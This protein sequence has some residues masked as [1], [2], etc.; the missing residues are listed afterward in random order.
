[1][2]VLDVGAYFGFFTLHFARLTQAQG[3]VYA[4]EIDP[5]ILPLLYENIATNGAFNAEVVEVG[6]LD[7]SE[8]LF[9]AGQGQLRS[10]GDQST[11]PGVA[12]VAFDDWRIGRDIP[13]VDLVKMD[14]EGAELNALLGMQQLLC[15]DGPLLL[16][17]VHPQFIENFDHRVG[18]LYDFLRSLGYEIFDVNGTR[19]DGVSDV[20][21]ILCRRKTD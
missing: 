14:I 6:L 17:E 16:I 4:F 7:R 9:L 15:Q 18:E 13:K 10:G 1:M 12:V 19:I 11:N 3:K 20:E 21:H 8:K 2:T 5:E